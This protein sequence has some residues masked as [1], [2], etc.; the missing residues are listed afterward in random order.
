MD[1]KSKHPNCEKLDRTV[2]Q[3][4]SINSKREDGEGILQ[5]EE[6]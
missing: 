6:I 4:P 1:T 5:M 3:F 2:T